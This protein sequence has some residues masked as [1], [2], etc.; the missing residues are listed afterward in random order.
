MFKK[1]TT[2]AALSTALVFG[3]ATAAN[4]QSDSGQQAQPSAKVFYKVQSNFG[5]G[6][7]SEE[8]INK[9]VN[10]F[11]K[12][13]QIDWKQ[14]QTPQA[15]QQQPKQEAPA[16][17]KVEQ[18]K[19][20][21]PK[22][23]PAEQKAEAPAAP[24]Q[25]APQQQEAPA[26]KPAAEQNQNSQLNEFEQQVVELTNQKR[27]E[28]GLQPLKVDTELSKVAR[29]KSRDMAQNGYFSHNSPTYGS[30][31]DMMKQ[32]GIDYRTA[33]EN[34]AKGQRSPQEVV[35]AWMNSEGHRKNILS[36][37]FTHIGVGYVENGNVWTQQF[38]GK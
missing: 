24:A 31:F 19:E 14:F 29:E 37:D 7:F 3:G 33:G 18:P 23:Q 25:P 34:I 1:I 30:P 5:A 32:F 28:N 12:D 10:S 2:V 21:A 9:F 35:N 17:P 20:E 22:E 15:P 8:D 11:L 38:I 13:Y 16:K 36:S 26:E 27:Q 6:S 4:A